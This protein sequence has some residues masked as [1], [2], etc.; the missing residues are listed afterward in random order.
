MGAFR[1]FVYSDE[2]II[3]HQYQNEIDRLKFELV[4]YQ[5]TNGE[6][7][8]R[9]DKL[10]KHAGALEVK[11]Q[12]FKKTAS[13]DQSEIKDLRVKLRTSEHERA[14]LFAKQGESGETKRALQALESKR[15]DELKERDRKIAELENA[16]A[17]E[18]KKREIAEMRA[19]EIERK[20][21]EELREACTT[22]RRLEDQVNVA[23]DEALNAQSSLQALGS[24]T[25]S[26]E[27]DLVLQLEHYRAMLGR[28]AE[29][30]GRL[31][32]T[33]VPASTHS[34]INYEHSSLQMQLF[35][36]ERKLAN[37]EGQVVELAN[38]V[39]HTMETNAS[40]STR[41]RDVEQEVIFYS[42][43]LHDLTKIR[44]TFY[45]NSERAL[46]DNL[47]AIATDIHDCRTQNLETLVLESE[48]VCQFYRIV[49]G[50]LLQLF[51]SADQS[52]EAKE[53]LIQQRVAELDTALTTQ[54]SLTTQ[55]QVVQTE[56]DTALAQL[57]GLVVSMDELKIA[58]EEA[59][60]N[61]LAEVSKS[62]E[63]L[64]N[65]RHTI[66]SL[67]STVQKSR[68]AEE[69]LRADIDQCVAFCR[70]WKRH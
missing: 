20:K 6:Q 35:R 56:R 14:Q 46:Q 34:R 58:L 63:T 10:K 42:T 13:T 1:A 51:Y 2:P 52:L 30:Y 57:N 44:D 23:R 24:A 70:V 22:A 61:R 45:L 15:R 18:R 48:A 7:S 27:Q 31:V 16:L 8:E 17:S 50:D 36:L 29:E 62:E 67:T 25:T 43:G 5:K 4:R 55:L 3:V 59:E 38:L 12:E 9:I 54:I 64:K 53:A 26:K 32:S 19:A 60:T 21:E 65:E 11:I 47:E 41:L 69:A 33:T 28:V 37:S 40:L 68:M 49:N 66:Q 39:R